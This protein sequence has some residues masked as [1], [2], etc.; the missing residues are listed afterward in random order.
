MKKTLLLTTLTSMTLAANADRSPYQNLNYADWGRLQ[1]VDNQLSDSKGDP[2]QL[3]G[4]STYSLH[5][6]EV[7]GCLGKGQ[8][9]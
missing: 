3:K 1:L 7:Q 8:W 2:V 4:W 6:G 9:G 5:Y